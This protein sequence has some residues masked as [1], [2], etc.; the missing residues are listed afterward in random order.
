[1]LQSKVKETYAG[2]RIMLVSTQFC[3]YGEIP[4]TMRAQLASTPV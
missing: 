2:L 4:R 1:M 3:I